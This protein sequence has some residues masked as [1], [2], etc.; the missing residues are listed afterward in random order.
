MIISASSK[1]TRQYSRHGVAASEPELPSQ[2]STGS[3]HLRG[4]TNN[5][6]DGL[7][8][9]GL[10]AYGFRGLRAGRF[11]GLLGGSGDLV[12]RYFRDL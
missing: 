1:T 8:L 3:R 12:S 2:A 7:G 6:T 11:M 10:G 4:S 9:G 5:Q